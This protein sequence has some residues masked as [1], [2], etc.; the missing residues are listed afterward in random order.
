MNVGS[1]FFPNGFFYCFHENSW[2]QGATWIRHITFCSS[3]F[4]FVIDKHKNPY[5]KFC[6]NLYDFLKFCSPF[7]ILYFEFG[8]SDS[9]SVYNDPKNHCIPNLV[10]TSRIF[11]ISSLTNCS[12]LRGKSTSKTM[13]N[14]LNIALNF[15]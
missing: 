12:Y 5:I 14:I 10:R 1:L 6:K 3:D 15:F 4:K 7:L 13:K 2:V 9:I 11:I 8:K